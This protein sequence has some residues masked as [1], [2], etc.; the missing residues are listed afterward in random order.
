[1]AQQ[2]G[3]TVSTKTVPDKKIMDIVAGLNAHLDGLNQHFVGR[4]A[5]LELILLG[6]IMNEH[7]LL[8]GPPGTG[9]S[10]AVQAVASGIKANSF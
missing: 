7:V 9:K 8:I 2:S 10:A 3:N 6:L 5:M 4:R 1:M